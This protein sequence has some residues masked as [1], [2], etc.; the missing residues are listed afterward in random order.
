MVKLFIN[1]KEDWDY[2]YI[3]DMQQLGSLFEWVGN[4]VKLE[5][6]EF[7]SQFMNSSI[8]ADMDAWHPWYSNEP[9]NLLFKHFNDYKEKFN[10]QSIPQ[11]PDED[12][13]YY[14]DEL[15]WV[16]MWY[17]YLHYCL[18]MSSKDIYKILPLEKARM[19]YPIG[20]EMSW[21]GI[22]NR[23]IDEYNSYEQLKIKE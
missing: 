7:V 14:P 2:C 18:N 13:D 15:R 9:C 1:Y 19:Y 4:E 21:E 11:V 16:G 8:R 6:N 22:T 12:I 3:Q 17:A 10:L 5:M 23:F 20:H